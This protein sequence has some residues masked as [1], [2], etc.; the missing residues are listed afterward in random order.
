[1]PYIIFFNFYIIF[2]ILNSFYFKKLNFLFFLQQ[3]IFLIK[4]IKN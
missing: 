4:M 2:L 3:N 1:M